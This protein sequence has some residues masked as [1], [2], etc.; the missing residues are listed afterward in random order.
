LRDFPE[1]EETPLLHE[2]GV[3]GE[4]GSPASADA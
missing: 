3:I 4:L 2:E 1:M